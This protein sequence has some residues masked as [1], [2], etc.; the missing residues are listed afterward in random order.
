MGESTLSVEQ[1]LERMKFG[2]KIHHVTWCK[3]EYARLHTDGLIYFF[4]V[5]GN[6][7][8]KTMTIKQFLNHAGTIYFEEVKNKNHKDS[9]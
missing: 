5:N 1:A 2:E 6:W 4:P 3:G 7:D 9:K 8:C